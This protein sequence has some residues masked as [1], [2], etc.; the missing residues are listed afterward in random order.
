VKLFEWRW[1]IVF[2]KAAHLEFSFPNIV[3]LKYGVAIARDIQH[4]DAMRQRL[5]EFQ[6]S[7]QSGGY[8]D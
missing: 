1:P 7:G 3:H 6:K 2:S 8:Y 4:F 5:T